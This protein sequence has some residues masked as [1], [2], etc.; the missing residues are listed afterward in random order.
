MNKSFSKRHFRYIR[1][2]TLE[3][4]RPH[5]IIFITTYPKT[6]IGNIKRRL[7]RKK[8]LEIPITHVDSL[9]SIAAMI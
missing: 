3:E 8:Y 1:E 2:R 9:G 7:L 6:S 5:E 4:Q